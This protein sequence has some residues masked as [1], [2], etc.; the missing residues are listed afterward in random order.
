MIFDNV[1]C[2]SNVHLGYLMTLWPL[3]GGSCPDGWYYYNGTESCFYVST[4]QL[5]QSTARSRCQQMDAD[6]A[7]ISD[8]AEMNFVISIS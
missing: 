5:D 3:L 1:S 6:L 2:I 8:Q 4:T 7:S